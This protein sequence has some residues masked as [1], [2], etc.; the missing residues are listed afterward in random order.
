MRKPA[1][2]FDTFVA[3]LAVVSATASAGC[4][5][6]E[7]AAAAP[8]PAAPAVV[9]SAVD[10]PPA[11]PA[12]QATAAPAPAPESAPSKITE[13]PAK[14]A[15]PSRSAVTAIPV[16]AGS[17]SDKK[18]ADPMTCGAGGCTADMKKGN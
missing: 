12:A 4:S 14:D 15:K 18:K 11:T 13:T 9:S 3:A 6:A 8:E 5:K 7:H 2:T 1:L 16:D 10:P 17:A